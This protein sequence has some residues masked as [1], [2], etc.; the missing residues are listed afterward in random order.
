MSRLT[1]AQRQTQIIEASLEIIKQGG[2]QKLTVKEIA[3]HIGISE[4]AIYRHFSSKLEILTS[5]IS[6]FNSNL[7]KHLDHDLMS[8]SATERIKAVTNAHLDYLQ[9]HPAVAAVIFSEEIFQNETSLVQA[10]KNALLERLNTMASL[11]RDGQKSGEFKADYDA[12][13]LAYLFLGS[14]RLIVVHWR[15]SGFS[16]NVK[17]KGKKMVANL[18]NL[19]QN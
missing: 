17:E 4:Q 16:F 6:Y 2:I 9:S 1:T 8:G 18:I 5:I 3:R 11:L 7:K 10:V 14:L 13:E 19:L 15:L 12:D